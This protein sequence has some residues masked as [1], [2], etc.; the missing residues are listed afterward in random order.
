VAEHLSGQFRFGPE[1]HLLRYPGFPTPLR[2]VTPFLGQVESAVQEGLPLGSDVD[3]KDPDLTV[4][5]FADRAGVLPLDAYGFRALFQKAGVVKDPDAFGM[6]QGLHD[7]G[8]QFILCGIRIPVG[9]IQEPLGAVGRRIAHRLGYLPSVLAGDRGQ[10]PPQVF[11]S[12]LSGLAAGKE[13][14]EPGM[15]RFKVFGPRF[16]LFWGHSHSS[17]EWVSR[18][19]SLRREV[20]TSAVV[21]LSTSVGPKFAGS[22]D[23]TGWAF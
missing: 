2:V 7:K 10:K 15:K 17:P 19:L 20:G 8:D 21:V 23:T 3:Q 12:L 18:L 22:G 1:L 6:A 4:F 5:H 13:M 11:C 14:G 16:Q 9:P